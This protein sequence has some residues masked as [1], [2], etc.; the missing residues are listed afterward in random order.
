MA[1]ASEALGFILLLTR[2]PAQDRQPLQQLVGLD[3][4]RLDVESDGER[5]TCL[6][7]HRAPFRRPGDRG[8]LLQLGP[9]GAERDGGDLGVRCGHGV[10]TACGGR[11][12]W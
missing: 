12:A 5:P 1:P 4:Q 8:R 6:A 7:V 10:V 3:G 11:K 9:H 2:H